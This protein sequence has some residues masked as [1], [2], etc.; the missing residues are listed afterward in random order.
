MSL[1]IKLL[2]TPFTLLDKVC[3]SLPPILDHFDKENN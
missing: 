1:L 2:D 3:D